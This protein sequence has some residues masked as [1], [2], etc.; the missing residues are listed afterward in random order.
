VVVW[1]WGWT[2]GRQLVSDSYRDA[3]KMEADQRAKRKERK[4][5]EESAA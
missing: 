3:K 1:A 4:L 5:A 2:G